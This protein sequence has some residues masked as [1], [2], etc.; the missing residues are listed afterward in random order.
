M[1]KVIRAIKLIPKIKLLGIAV[2]IQI[3]TFEYKCVENG[4]KD[5]HT[6]YK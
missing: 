6:Y 1:F 3:I 2:F 5:S 4:R